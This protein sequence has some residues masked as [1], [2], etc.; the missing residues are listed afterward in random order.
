VVGLTK[1]KNPVDIKCFG[2]KPF[3]GK[4]FEQK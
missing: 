4:C 1:K 2:R 3:G